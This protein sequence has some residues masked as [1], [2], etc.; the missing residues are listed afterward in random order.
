M[1]EVISFRMDKN[2][3][4]E[5]HALD[6]LNTWIDKGFNTRFI[7]TKALLELDHPDFDAEETRNDQG[8]DVV[9]DQIGRVLEIVKSLKVNPT[10]EKHPD[11][12][13]S[14][15]NDGFIESI[16]QGIK[17]GIRSER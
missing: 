7:L 11:N 3:P 9:L 16:R 15:L 12:E 1:S 13:H 8:V 10:R 14:G 6:V 17:P 4:R 5:A 2:N